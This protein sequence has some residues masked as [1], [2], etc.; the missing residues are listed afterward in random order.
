MAAGLGTR[1]R[2]AA[3]EAPAPAAREADD[4]LGARG[5]A[6]AL[7]GSARRRHVAGLA[8]RTGGCRGRPARRPARASSA[9]ETPSP[10]HASA[11]DGS[12][13]DIL[14]LSGDTPLL[15]ADLLEEL[16]ARHRSAGAAVTVLSF[17]PPDAGAY[18]RVLRDA[19]GA[20]HA[21]VEA[22]D[23]SP[24]ELAVTRGEQL[25]LHLRARRALGRHRDARA[26]QR[27]GRALPHRLRAAPSS[28]TEEPGPC[29][30]PLTGARLRASTRA[31]SSPVLRP[32]SA[33]A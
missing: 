33:T 8:G 18:G 20:L 28:A 26:T 22:G 12:A 1:M 24:A 19:D 15:T 27:A 10:R 32:S 11:L 3:A 30:P 14:V 5:R 4:R 6:A 9:P 13:A 25:D 21:I 7:A 23:A 16:A 2:S 31:P 29:L 17:E